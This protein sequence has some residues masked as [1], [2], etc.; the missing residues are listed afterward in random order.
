MKQ[1]D[2]LHAPAQTC[3]TGG[4]PPCASPRGGGGGGAD[5]STAPGAS[6]RL[7]LPLAGLPPPLQ[8]QPAVQKQSLAT[9]VVAIIILTSHIVNSSNTNMIHDT[10]NFFCSHHTEYSV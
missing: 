6:E 5:L 2:S 4:W 7:Q 9:C 1:G 10:F 8:A 3:P